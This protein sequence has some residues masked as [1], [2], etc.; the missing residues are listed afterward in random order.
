M[1]SVV[2]AISQPAAL[3]ADEVLGRHPDVGE[4]GH[5]VLDAAQAHEGVAV[6]HL[7]ARRRRLDD[8]GADA[9]RGARATWGP[10]P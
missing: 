8:E 1:L 9:R 7:D 10:W 3:L 4:P 6:Q 2:S 5:A